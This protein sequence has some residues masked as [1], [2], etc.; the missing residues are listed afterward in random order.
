M[1]QLAAII[2]RFPAHE[3]I[4]RR[5]YASTAEFRTLCEDYETAQQALERWRSDERKAEEFRLLCEEIEE[6]VGEQLEK[7]SSWSRQ[8]PREDI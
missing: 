5:L 6:E 3:L 2:R 4:I 1:P 7:A 8:K